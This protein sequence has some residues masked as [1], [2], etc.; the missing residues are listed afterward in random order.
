MAGDWIKIES[1]TP[2]KPEVYQMAAELGISPEQVVGHLVR[3]WAWADQQ[4]LN[5]H[6]LRVTSVTV[7][8][9]SRHACFSQALINCG[10]LVESGGTITFPNFDNHNGET[11]KQRGLANK[12]KA[13]Q[14]A[15]SH[16]E[17]TDVSRNER[18]QNRD[19]RREEKSNN[20]IY[21]ARQSNVPPDDFEPDDSTL[22]R[23]KINGFSEPENADVVA[24][25]SHYA[26]HPPHSPVND[27]QAK[28]ISWMAKQRAFD[29]ANGAKN[30]KGKANG[31]RGNVNSPAGAAASMS[32]FLEQN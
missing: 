18:D 14:R 21:S 8:S 10:W 28:F 26:A 27:W 31:G 5:G 30:G 29:A 2:D 25:V 3:V 11:A 17:V 12:R 15:K 32:A 22:T 16:A 19:Q 24:F 7:D 1:V 23:L 20:S 6:A 9:V 4:S 13:K